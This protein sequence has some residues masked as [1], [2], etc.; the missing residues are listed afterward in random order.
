MIYRLPTFLYHPTHVSLGFKMDWVWKFSEM[1]DDPT[2][3]RYCSEMLLD[4]VGSSGQGKQRFLIWKCVQSTV[5]CVPMDTLGKFP[6]PP[7]VLEIIGPEAKFENPMKAIYIYL[8]F[9]LS[10]NLFRRG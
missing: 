10:F 1:L 8:L 2:F 6:G 4:T 3:K 7:R 9:E 5:V